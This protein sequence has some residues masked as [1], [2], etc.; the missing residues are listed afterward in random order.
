MDTLR[1]PSLTRV[2]YS[3]MIWADGCSHKG[4]P[5]INGMSG[6]W[7]VMAETCRNS[8]DLAGSYPL[9]WFPATFLPHQLRFDPYLASNLKVSIP[10][11]GH[12]PSFVD[13]RRSGSYGLPGGL[14]HR[15]QHIGPPRRGWSAK[16]RSEMIPDWYSQGC[17]SLGWFMFIFYFNQFLSIF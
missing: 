6:K 7:S 17:W 2:C 9:P 12:G 4:T 13:R 5:T 16:P 15:K 11:W 3:T 14:I 10:P 8:V 1:C